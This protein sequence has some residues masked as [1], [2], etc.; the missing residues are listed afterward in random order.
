VPVS[1]GFQS[2][3]GPSDTGSDRMSPMY[4]RLLLAVL[5][6]EVEPANGH[7][8]RSS[9]PLAEL[10]R[11]RHVMDKHAERADPGWALQAVADQLAYDAAL[12]RLAR[13]R[14]VPVDLGCFDVP[15]QG[16]AALE[17]A[18]VDKG[19]NI[20]VRAGPEPPPGGGAP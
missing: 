1:A 14:G 11:L 12:V 7:P 4:A 6:D 9:G 3:P 18:L 8:T 16:R 20:P 5:T 19:V 10:Q 17:Q 13:K 2:G 15:E